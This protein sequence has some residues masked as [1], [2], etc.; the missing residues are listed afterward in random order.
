MRVP[1]QNRRPHR[2]VLELAGLRVG[3][4]QHSD[5]DKPDAT[6][7]ANE[8]PVP[9]SLWPVVMLSP[10]ST[11]DSEASSDQEEEEE[12]S[13]PAYSLGLPS[14]S[15]HA[16]KRRLSAFSTYTQS[17]FYSHHSRRGLVPA[18]AQ[19][20]S[21]GSGASDVA[22]DQSPTLPVQPWGRGKNKTHTAKKS[23]STKNSS[24]KSKTARRSRSQ[25]PPAGNTR[26]RW[27]STP[28]SP[29]SLAFTGDS[30]RSFPSSRRSNTE[31]SSVALASPTLVAGDWKYQVR[32]G[33]HMARNDSEDPERDSSA[34]SLIPRSRRTCSAAAAPKAAAG[35]TAQKAREVGEA[36]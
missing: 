21:P 10:T 25:R 20:S 29:Q 5:P 11:T 22:S 16:D 30:P 28:S 34:F 24:G 8:A 2:Q 27:D 23:S 17:S 7:P 35:A 32:S 3:A 1:I 12:E 26:P 31:A 14:P 9:V 15:H 36:A 4:R 19:P 18:V 13:A 6:S 33:I